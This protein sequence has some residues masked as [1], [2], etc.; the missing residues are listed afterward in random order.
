MTKNVLSSF[1]RFLH[2]DEEFQS[3]Y[4]IFH[5]FNKSTFIDTT[6]KTNEK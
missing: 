5:I 2:G 1:L 6:E 3:S 4:I